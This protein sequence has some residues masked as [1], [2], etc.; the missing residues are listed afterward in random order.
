MRGFTLVELLVVITIIAL[1]AGLLLPVIAGAI[2]KAEIHKALGEVTAIAMA[3][4]HY[5]V[6]YTKYPG[7]TA[8]AVSDHQYSAGGMGSEYYKLINVLRGTNFDATW[9]NPRGIV[10]LSVDDRSI[11]TNSIGAPGS[12]SAQ[13][14]EMTDPWG[15]HYEVIADWNF[16]NRIDSPL[17]DGVKV[18]GRGVAV[19]SYG[20]WTANSLPAA[21][22]GKNIHSWK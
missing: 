22:S 9:S 15:D 12:Y 8:G 14:Q 19:W 21:G 2:K 1:L 10:F 18:G 7:Q 11:A 3:V 16:D 4:E 20:P 5:Q 6:E 13:N 17:A